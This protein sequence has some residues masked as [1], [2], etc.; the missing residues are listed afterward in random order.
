VQREEGDRGGDPAVAVGD[1][2]LVLVFRYAGLSELPSDLLVG[3]EGATLGV[4][5]AIGVKVSSPGH[6][7]GTP[8]PTHHSTRVLALVARVEDEGSVA[9]GRE[10]FGVGPPVT[11]LLGGEDRRL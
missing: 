4:E 6:A 7:P 9:R 3:V 2:G 5:E 10:R 11:P 8:I 1:D